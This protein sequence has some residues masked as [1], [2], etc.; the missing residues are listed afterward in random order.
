ME[1]KKVLRSQTDTLYDSADELAEAIKKEKVY[2]K[3]FKKD[4]SALTAAERRQ[5]ADFEPPKE[6]KNKSNKAV[7]PKEN[8]GE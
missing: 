1:K 2:A 6:G 3:Y 7:E 4:S 5:A 8:K